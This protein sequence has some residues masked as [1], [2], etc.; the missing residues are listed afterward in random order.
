MNISKD[1]TLEE[2]LTVIHRICSRWDK[3]G[4][5]RIECAYH[6][7]L[8]GAIEVIRMLSR[9]NAET[10]ELNR[11]LILDHTSPAKVFAT[12]CI[13]GSFGYPPKPEILAGS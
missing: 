8:L 7:D 12:I 6:R 1:W 11:E 4:T 9:L 3:D 2:R 13:Q 10:C 5:T